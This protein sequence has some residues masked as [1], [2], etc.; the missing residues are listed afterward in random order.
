MSPYLTDRSPSPSKKASPSR[1]F[2]KPVVYLSPS[3]LV[4][5]ESDDDVESV[6]PIRTRARGKQPE[7]SISSPKAAAGTD[8]NTTGASLPSN[9]T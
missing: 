9:G 5:V 2:R 3:K 4:E 7:R 1:A 8:N 6:E